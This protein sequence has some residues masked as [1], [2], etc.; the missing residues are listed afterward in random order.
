MR[1]HGTTN[2]QNGSSLI[3]MMIALVVL[4]VGLLGSMALVSV[5]IGGDYRSKSDSTSTA[6][7]EMVAQKISAYPV[8][9]GCA[10]APAVSLTD[11]AGNVHP[12][13]VTGVAGGAGANLTANGR[14]DY[15]Q[16]FAA[17]PANYAMR[18]TVCGVTNGTQATYD[19]RWNIN[20]LPSNSS[21]LVVV[22]AQTINANKATPLA[23]APAVNIRTVIGNDGN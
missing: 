16:G 19:V 17:V 14:I 9:N 18:Y 15:A 3:E 1:R 10:P 5:A 2:K 11:C 22:A 7:A 6:L 8:C 23:N 12:I 13:S 4:T 21:E 20:L